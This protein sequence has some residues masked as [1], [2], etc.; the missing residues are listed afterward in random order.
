M[1]VTKII[2]KSKSVKL[3]IHIEGIQEE[4]IISPGETSNYNE[5]PFDKCAGG[6]KMMDIKIGDINPIS[7]WRGI[8]PCGSKSPIKI[9]PELRQVTCD[10]QVLPSLLPEIKREHFNPNKNSVDYPSITVCSLLC[11]FLLIILCIVLLF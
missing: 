2:N 11:L 5:V 8:I 1:T 10:G 7:L 3:K 4:K 6:T 9:Y